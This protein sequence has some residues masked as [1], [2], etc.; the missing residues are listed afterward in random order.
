MKKK[1]TEKLTPM[2]NFV[3]IKAPRSVCSNKIAALPVLCKIYSLTLV[4]SPITTNPRH[5]NWLCY[6]EVKN[7]DGECYLFGMEEYKEYFRKID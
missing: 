6:I 7:K 2:G 3:C 5:F 4:E 1:E